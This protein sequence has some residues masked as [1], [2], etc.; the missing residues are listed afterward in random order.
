MEKE[1]SDVTLKAGIEPHRDWEAEKTFQ[2]EG[3]SDRGGS[4]GGTISDS[5]YWIS[6]ISQTR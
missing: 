1:I 3:R 2:P 6:Q 4:N 5:S